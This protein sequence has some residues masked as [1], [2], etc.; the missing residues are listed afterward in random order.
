MVSQAFSGYEI[1]FMTGVEIEGENEVTQKRFREE[2]QSSPPSGP[3]PGR[4]EGLVQAAIH[5]SQHKDGET[6]TQRGQGHQPKAASKR[7]S[8]E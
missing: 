6:E 8:W 3:R 5:L 4:P 2:P 1:E 7:Q